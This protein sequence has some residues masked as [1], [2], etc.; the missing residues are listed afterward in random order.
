LLEELRPR[1]A[2]AVLGD[3]RELGPIAD[4]EHR[5]VGRRVAEV[6]DVLVTFGP[7]AR[8]IAAEAQET[9][10]VGGPGGVEGKPLTVVSFGLDQRADLIAYLRA[11]LRGGDVV[12]LKGSRGLEMEDIVAAIRADVVPEPATAADAAAGDTSGRGA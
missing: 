3:M 7:L 8:I 9:A 11:K 4:E 5:V 1:R 10:H 6:A 2:I 12:L